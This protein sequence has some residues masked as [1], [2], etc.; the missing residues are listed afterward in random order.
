ML[1][2][3]LV[4]LFQVKIPKAGVAAA[5]REDAS[6]SAD[7]K[8]LADG[9]P[10]SS[11]A[12]ENEDADGQDGQDEEEDEYECA[13]KVGALLTERLTDSFP[14]GNCVCL[15]H[16]LAFVKP[17]IFGRN[18]LELENFGFSAEFSCQAYQKSV[19]SAG[20][21]R[22]PADMNTAYQ[23]TQNHTSVLDPALAVNDAAKA[24]LDN[25][26]FGHSS[27]IMLC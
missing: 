20:D 5:S 21:G 12:A 10:G 24:L 19:G 14:S 9:K 26:M 13:W 18:D 8:A 6:N 22:K 2:W 7:R 25:V 4:W 3:P 27:M 17:T 23:H 15:K 16:H 1:S 11:E